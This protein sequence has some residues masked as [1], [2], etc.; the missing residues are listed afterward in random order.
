MDLREQINRAPSRSDRLGLAAIFL[1]AC[2]VAGGYQ[3]HARHLGIARSLWAAGVLLAIAM[4][5]PALGHRLYVAWMTLG[6]VLGLVTS[7]IFL[8]IIYYLVVV[9]IG[10]LTRLGGRNAMR[11]G[12]EPERASYWEDYPRV[13]DQERYLKQY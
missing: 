10:L 6:I 9:P 13:E 8:A 7:P 12:P 2:G 11:R 4:L 5:V 1:V 3:H